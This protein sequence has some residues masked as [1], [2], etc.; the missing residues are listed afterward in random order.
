MPVCSQDIHGPGIPGPCMSL[1]GK[2]RRMPDEGAV[3]G[4][5][6]GKR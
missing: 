1:S 3:V 2:R 4:K 5:P 6:E